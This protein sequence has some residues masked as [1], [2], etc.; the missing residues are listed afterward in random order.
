MTMIIQDAQIAHVADLLRS[1][2]VSV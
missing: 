2:K 1:F